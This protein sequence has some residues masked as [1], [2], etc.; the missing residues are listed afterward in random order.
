[1]QLYLLGPP[2]FVFL[3]PEVIEGVV[4]SG[5]VDPLLDTLNDWAGWGDITVTTEV[6]VTIEED[7]PSETE[8]DSGYE[9]D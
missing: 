3:I 4:G 8:N 7:S 5:L 6:E 2:F 1:M 9:S